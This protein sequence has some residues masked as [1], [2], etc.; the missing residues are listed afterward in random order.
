MNT[1]VRVESTPRTSQISWH[2]RNCQQSRPPMTGLLQWQT[3]AT[4]SVASAKGC[5]GKVVWLYA[6]VLLSQKS[7]V[8][9]QHGNLFELKTTEKQLF[10]FINIQNNR[11]ISLYQ[12][13]DI[14]YIVHM[15]R[16]SIIVALTDKHWK[17]SHI[18]RQILNVQVTHPKSR[19]TAMHWLILFHSLHFT[20]V[21]LSN[22]SV[23]ACFVYPSEVFRFYSLICN[24]EN[25]KLK[26]FLDILLNN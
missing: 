14:F 9:W 15:T 10:L 16:A 11:I 26:Y 24:T 21:Q 2:R 8:N 19:L 20:S 18:Y 7:M 12:L 23:L 13:A 22:C 17:H 1:Y 25:N 6:K 4:S 5:F 3:T